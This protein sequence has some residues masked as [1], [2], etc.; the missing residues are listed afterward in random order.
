M[1][2]S[3]KGKNINNLGGRIA[4]EN[5]KLDADKNITNKGGSIRARVD[6]ILKGENVI[7]EANVKESQYKG[8]N[9]KTVGNTGSI[10][11]GQNL[12]INAEK[13]II[14]KGSVLAADK[15]LEFTSGKDTNIKGGKL[16]GEKV[17]G[18][19]GGDLNIESKQDKN[20]YDSEF[21][22]AKSV[23]FTVAGDYVEKKYP[24]A[25]TIITEAGII[26]AIN[27]GLDK[28]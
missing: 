26:T 15:N 8:L 22:V 5:V 20:S 2:T 7:N 25:I 28:I 27:T 1:D 16:S 10:S 12:S 18:N 14:N 23:M 13:D 4:G 17:T 24:G 9:Q 19:V 11:A 6:A 21:D 3:F